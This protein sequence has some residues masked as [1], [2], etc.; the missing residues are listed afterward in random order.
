MGDR[1]AIQSVA[2]IDRDPLSDFARKL[3]R[4][5]QIHRNFVPR[6]DAL[7]RTFSAEGPGRPKDHHAHTAGCSIVARSWV[8]NVSKPLWAHDSST[9]PAH[10]RSEKTMNAD[11]IIRNADLVD[12]TGAPVTRA[13]LAVRDGKIEAVTA[14][15]ELAGA[16]AAEVIDAEGLLVTPGF[17]DPHTH[18]DGQ[19]TWDDRLAPSADHGVS[20]VVVG[21]CGV[22]FAPGPAGP[23]GGVDRPDGRG[24]RHSRRGAARRHQVGLGELSR[25]P[26]RA[27]VHAARRRSR[28]RSCLTARCG[29][30]RSADDGRRQRAG[31]GCAGRRDGAP[32]RGSGRCGRRRVLEQPHHAPHVDLGRGRAGHLRRGAGSQRDHEGGAEEMAAGSSRSCPPVSWARTRTASGANSRSTGQVSLDT[33]CTVLFTVAQNNV[34]PDLWRELFD[35]ADQPRTPKAPQLVPMTINRPGGLLLSWE[36]FHPFVDR[37]SYVEIAELPIAERLAALRDPARRARIIEEPIQTPMFKHAVDIVLSSLG[38][39]FLPSTDEINEPDPA[40]SLG[41]IIEAKGIAPLEGVYDALCD[42]SEGADGAGFLNVFMGNYAEGNLGAV[43]EMLTR[44]GTLVG[45]GDGGAHVTVICDASYPTYM[46]Q[47]W[48]RER[49][50]GERFAIEQAV[51]MLTQDPAELYGMKDR[52][53]VAKG[54]RADLNVIDLNRIAL[55]RPRVEH[56]LPSGAPR[57]LQSATGYK[58]TIVGGQVTSRDGVDTGARPGGLYRA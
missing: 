3:F 16:S 24:R 49:K 40:K 25:I 52:G 53:I 37:P 47:H 8:A 20:T 43:H 11:L 5:P 41:G 56:D 22:G 4:R 28:S 18:Y 21:N 30:T 31:V 32:G 46:L 12:G 57:L 7:L 17:I 50:R 26:R 42:A 54:L 38:S 14:A 10:R 58:A 48:V 33:G 55:G 6:F 1:V 23:Q 27:R 13:D 51:K 34:Q 15:G 44:P 45:G 29:R 39:T 9:G 35:L 2:L 19:A 36:T